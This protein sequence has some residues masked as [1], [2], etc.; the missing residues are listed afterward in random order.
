MENYLKDL[1]LLY[2]EICR[3]IDEQGLSPKVVLDIIVIE[4]VRAAILVNLTILDDNDIDTEAYR[5][6]LHEYDEAWRLTQVCMKPTI[7]AQ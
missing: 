7:E 2:T 1:T 6:E 4:T 5:L 3:T